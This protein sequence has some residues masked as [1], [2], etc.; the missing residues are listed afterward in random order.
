[1]TSQL[2]LKQIANFDHDGSRNQQG[3]RCITERDK[4][5]LMILIVSIR[6]GNEWSSVD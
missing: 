2:P 1:M 4:G 6:N 3:P 5:R